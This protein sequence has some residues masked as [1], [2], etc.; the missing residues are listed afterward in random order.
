MIQHRE[1]RLKKLHIPFEPQ[2][3]K[4][5]PIKV[6]EVRAKQRAEWERCRQEK[7]IEVERQQENKQRE[8]E[9]RVLP[10]KNVPPVHVANDPVPS[11]SPMF[12]I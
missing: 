3:T 2:L 10:R 11:W 6:S 9:E 7:E 8:E 12:C 1:L 5:S 4:R